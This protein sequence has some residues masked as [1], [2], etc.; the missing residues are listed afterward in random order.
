MLYHHDNRD[1]DIAA[2]VAAN[3]ARVKMEEMIHR[4]RAMAAA[5]IEAVQNTVINDSI[6]RG[7]ALEFV[8]VEKDVVV[9]RPDS[10][11]AP[12]HRHGLNQA[13]ERTGIPHSTRFID[14]M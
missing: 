12:F 11:P 13:V 3:K 6:V 1:Y 7:A 4:G 10:R 2:S 8:N 5:T 14:T 9:V